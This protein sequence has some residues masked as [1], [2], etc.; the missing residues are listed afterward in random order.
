MGPLAPFN[1]LLSNKP[2]KKKFSPKFIVLILVLGLAA[3]F[4]IKKIVFSL[5][6]ETTDNAQVDTQI[7]PVLP[8]VAGYIKALYVKD[9]DSV[10]KGQLLAEL[11][12]AELQTQLQEAKAD[13]QQAQADAVAAEAAIQSA[14][15]A[16]EVSKG[17]LQ[18]NQVKQ[19]KAV[20]DEARDQRL[21]SE[22]ALTRKA[23][24]ETHYNLEIARQNLSMSQAELSVTASKIA[25][26][27]ANLQRVRDV[28]QI[29]QAR[30]DQLQLKLS[31][32]QIVSPMSGRI[33]KRNVAEGQ[34]VQAGTPF[35]AVVNDSAF[36]VIANF[37]ESQ[38]AALIPGK[39]VQLRIDAFP[40]LTITGTVNNLSEATGAKFALIPPD[41]ASGNFVKVSQRIPVK[42]TF[43]QLDQIRSYLR[44]GMSVFVTAN[45]N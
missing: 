21:L 13:L 23:A 20:Q 18:L 11:D 7:V 22:G 33:G 38:L 16:V 2:M 19:Q 28:V 10:S 39:K 36:W 5:T 43:D 40:D 25:G 6:H 8:R 31:Y 3:Y 42:I 14:Q 37:K 35:F 4:G 15:A 41:N 9:F 29:K 45:K 27:K 26:L 30:I 1:Y 44:A 32:T 34:L 12:D 24:E 17:S